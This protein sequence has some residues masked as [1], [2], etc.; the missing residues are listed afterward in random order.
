M[1]NSKYPVDGI[2][3]SIVEFFEEF[4]KDYWKL[5]E[6]INLRIFKYSTTINSNCHRPHFQSLDFFVQFVFLDATKLENFSFVS[7]Y[8]SKLYTLSIVTNIELY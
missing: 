6:I 1:M 3:F 5:E 8:N 4:F 2:I 7:N